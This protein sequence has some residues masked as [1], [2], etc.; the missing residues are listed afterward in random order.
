MERSQAWPAS[1]RTGVLTLA[2]GIGAFVVAA[3]IL[4]LTRESGSVPSIWP[5]N[6]IAL[7]ILLR[8]PRTVWAP[9]V[10]AM[11]AGNAAAGVVTGETVGQAVLLALANAVETLIAA[12]LL[13]RRFERRLSNRAGVARFIG[14]LSLACAASTLLA[15]MTLSLLGHDRP[16]AMSGLWFAADWL[17]LAIFGPLVSLIADRDNRA[18]PE[19]NRLWRTTAIFAA[20]IAVTTATFWQTQYP[21]LFLAPV[22]MAL[23][24]FQL[25]LGGAACASAIVAAI[26]VPLTFMGHGPVSLIH[27]DQTVRTLILQAFLGATTLMSLVVGA[28][29]AD[30]RN[31]V[32]RLTLASQ[33]AQLAEEMSNVGYWTLTPD[34]GEVFWSP[35]VYRIHGVTPATFDP[36]LDNAL[37]FY[38]AEDLPRLTEALAQGIA[39]GGGW[40]IDAAILRRSDGERREVRSLASCR[41]DETGKV[42][43]VF[44]VFKDMTDERRMTR[45]L[46]ENERKYRML[47]DNASDMI[48]SFT[49]AGEITFISPA[50][51]EILGY[52]PEELMGMKVVDL[53]H[54]D[55]RGPMLAH[56]QAL[57]ARGPD[58]V[59]TPY[60][61]RGRH[62][63]GRWIWLEGQPKVFYDET[64]GL[65]REIHDVARDVTKRKELELALARARQDAEA[66]AV[67]KATFLATMSHEIRTPLNGILGFAELLDGPDLSERQQLHVRRIRTAGQGLSALIND[68]L[69]FSR[70]DAGKMPI[71][72][73]PFDLRAL[74]ED[75][76][77]LVESGMPV[78]PIVFEAE[79]S[80]DISPVIEADDTR[81]RQILL[82]LLGNA[83]K[84]TDAGMI[85]ATADVEANQLVIRVTDTGPGIA[86]ENMAGLFEG[87]TQVDGSIAR[88]FGG[89]GLGLSI[90]RSLARLMDG[91]LTLESREGAGVTAILTLPYRPADVPAAGRGATA[92]VRATASAPLRVMIVD[93]GEMNRELVEIALH[94]AG[95][96]VVA[97]E[98]APG[99]IDRLRRDA[100]FDAVLMDVQMP[101]MDGLT[102]TRIIRTLDGPAADLPVIALT[103]NVLPDQIA[104]CRDA[105][106]DEHLA[107][108]LD[109]S[110]LFAVLERVRRG[111][112][113]A[114]AGHD[115]SLSETARNALDDLTRRYMDHVATLL[116]DVDRH[117][118]AR[119]VEQLAC[120]AHS[121]A[122]TAGSF[123]LTPLSDA[124]FDLEAAAK[125]GD[126]SDRL[127][128]EL[129]QAA[130]AFRTRCRD[131]AGSRA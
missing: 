64:T 18:W 103:A 111:A 96:E 5:L 93:D 79:L 87:F 11:V 69:D 58:A 8:S 37:A 21:L 60:H 52:S 102:A 53:T 61:F 128:S 16:V 45:A 32:S 117:M 119:D 67:A 44:G 88:R 130:E 34:T 83:A 19:R 131:V 54:P 112:A 120:L 105:G 85:R 70:I 23:V 30:R 51:V 109:M 55:D 22:I 77:A 108:P 59:S 35:E 89:S 127:R 28:A 95:H 126:D 129:D 101:G 84:F 116:D 110:A 49:P 78:K 104:A 65:P 71:H 66:A 27:G 56:Y 41:T 33:Q 123:G 91:D 15:F 42:V 43:A 90:S 94:E 106:M 124:A 115:G 73:H 82:N 80:D 29:V 46:V 1:L 74:V 114:K 17:G 25:G 62:R 125:R 72:D 75:V 2:T 92:S 121:V 118:A 47:A 36:S 6:A 107:K 57:F 68:I 48:A 97:F 50:S 14:V 86:P 3:A 20:L 10:L 38:P 122:G 26:A 7:V 9:V 39:T 113:T 81:L 98:D 63:D 4:L 100:A 76:M 31:L 12:S 99:A 40:S 13:D 24:A